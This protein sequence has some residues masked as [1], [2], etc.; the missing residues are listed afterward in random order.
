MQGGHR[1]HYAALIGR[2]NMPELS[3]LTL[4]QLQQRLEE[5]GA[6]WHAVEAAIAQKKDA[7]KKELAQEIRQKITDAGHLMSTEFCRF[8]AARIRRIRP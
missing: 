4:E 5:L 2:P 3:E 1:H 6:E 7:G 8:Q